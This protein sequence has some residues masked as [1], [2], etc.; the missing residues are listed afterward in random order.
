M[1]MVTMTWLLQI[2]LSDNVSVLLGNGDGTFQTS[3]EYG[4]GDAPIST[5]SADFTG[6]SNKDLV[7]ANQDSGTVSIL[8]GKW[9]W[10]I[11]KSNQL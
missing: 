9:R 10:I 7:V 8:P 4:A 3:I 11:S 5:S 1:K 2:F 6:D